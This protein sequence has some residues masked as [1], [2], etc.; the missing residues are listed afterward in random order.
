[1]DGIPTLLIDCSFRGDFIMEK[2]KKGLM[3]KVKIHINILVNHLQ[4]SSGYLSYSLQVVSS[5]KL[6]LFDERPVSKYT[7]NCH[8]TQK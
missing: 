7:I 6:N 8:N 2:K 3:Q 1:M 5:L 4:F